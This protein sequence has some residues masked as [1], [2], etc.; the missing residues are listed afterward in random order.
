MGILD[1]VKFNSQGLVPAIAQ[2]ADNGEVLMVAWMNQEALQYT[3]DKGIACY[4]SRSRK[5][6][7]IK[8]ETSGHIQKVLEI[9]LDCDGDVLLM[10]I[11]QEGGACHLGYRSCFF[12]KRK[13]DSWVIDG[14]KAFDPDQVYHN[15]K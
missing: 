6:L 4:F 15:K 5:K 7:W 2:D 14:K 1:E 10:K 13:D 3:L 12:R 9:R 8:G 11:R